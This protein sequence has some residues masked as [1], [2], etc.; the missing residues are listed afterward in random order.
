MF[1]KISQ[2]SQ[3]NTCARVSFLIK[4]QAWGIFFTEFI[5][6]IDFNKNILAGH[7][8]DS[9]SIGY[10]KSTAT[11][12]SEELEKNYNVPE[13]LIT[14]FHDLD[15]LVNFPRTVNKKWNLMLMLQLCHSKEENISL[16]DSIP[17]SSLFFCYQGNC[18]PRQLKRAR[19]FSQC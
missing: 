7:F 14:L 10:F 15:V 2:N 3:E 9:Q 12:S 17:C 6:A 18:L 16:I 19:L 11:H 13:S 5:V 1:F 4:L 8:F